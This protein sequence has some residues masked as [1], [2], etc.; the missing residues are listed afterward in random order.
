VE[1][2][3]RSSDGEKVGQ[4]FIARLTGRRAN[5]K[6]TSGAVAADFGAAASG[7]LLVTSQALLARYEGAVRSASR[8]P[9]EATSDPRASVR[10]PS[11]RIGLLTSTGT[12]RCR[13]GTRH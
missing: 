9:D 4:R 5:G 3:T 1:S 8:G 2:T 13:L 7:G 6:A 12:S 10:V 11:V